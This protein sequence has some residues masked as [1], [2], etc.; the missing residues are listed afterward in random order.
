MLPGPHLDVLVLQHGQRARFFVGAGCVN[1]PALR[2]RVAF[3]MI[4]SSIGALGFAPC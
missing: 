2:R 3:G 1:L 4:T